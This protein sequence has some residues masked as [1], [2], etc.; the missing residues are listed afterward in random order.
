MPVDRCVCQSVTFEALKDLA[1]REGLGLIGLVKKTG[2][3]TGCSNCIPYVRLMLKTGNTV[4]PVL[5][6][7]QFENALG[8]GCC[9]LSPDELSQKESGPLPAAKVR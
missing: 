8:K 3:C 1:G 6:R 7:W 4:F 5:N 2:C 9:Q